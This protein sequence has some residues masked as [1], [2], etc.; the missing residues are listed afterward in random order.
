MTSNPRSIAPKSRP[1]ETQEC[2]QSNALNTSSV[3]TNAPTARRLCTDREGGIADY[4]RYSPN[5]LLADCCGRLAYH[6]LDAESWPVSWGRGS[7]QRRPGLDRFD[8][9]WWSGVAEPE[10][11]S[12]PAS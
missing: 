10:L 6:L 4:L 2:A 7:R 3:L 12:A 5:V 1:P 9:G 8:E 11:P